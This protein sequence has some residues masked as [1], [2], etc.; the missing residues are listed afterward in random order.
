MRL[1]VAEGVTQQI[2]PTLTVG[3][4]ATGLALLLGAN[5]FALGIL[6]AMPV[7][8]ALM[9]FPAAWWIERTG[10]RRRLSVLGSPG[11]LLGLVPAIL[12]FLPLPAGARLGL[13]LLATAVG[14]ML[15]GS[16]SAWA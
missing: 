2:H 16:R 7:I 8:G 4:L 9:Q 14:Q 11:R 15:L 3:T 13:F 10:Q 12:L 6:A 5:S 1:G